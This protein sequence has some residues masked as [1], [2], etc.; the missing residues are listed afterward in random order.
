M[1]MSRVETA[2]ATRIKINQ[3][4]EHGSLILC[5]AR[6]EAGKSGR[7]ATCGS[8]DATFSGIYF[9]LKPLMLSL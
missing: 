5:D 9:A 1:A 6:H 4:A 2:E 8:L 7:M 3:Y